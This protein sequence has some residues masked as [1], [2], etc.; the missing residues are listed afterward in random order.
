MNI[1]LV[2]SFIIIYVTLTVFRVCAIQALA[3]RILFIYQ[4][5][6]IMDRTIGAYVGLFY[7]VQHLKIC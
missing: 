1:S 4:I 6:G 3:L 5:G 7:D 2:F